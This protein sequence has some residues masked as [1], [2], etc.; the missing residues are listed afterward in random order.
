M[1]TTDMENLDRFRL[2][3][4]KHSR[5][6]VVLLEKT[7]EAQTDMVCRFGPVT[8]DA[9]WMSSKDYG[10]PYWTIGCDVPYGADSLAVHVRNQPGP[11]ANEMTRFLWRENTPPKL[12]RILPKE[13][14][15]TG[16]TNRLCRS[17]RRHRNKHWSVSAPICPP[18]SQAG[19]SRPLR[20][21]HPT[22]IR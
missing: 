1:K 6:V 21:G 22:W 19:L 20:Q 13:G 5:S 16:G 15:S 3:E 17:N 9:I 4:R 11:Y 7:V 12:T 8:R 14:P 18:C 10:A 2:H